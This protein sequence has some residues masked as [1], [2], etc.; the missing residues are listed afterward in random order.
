MAC[1][2]GFSVADIAKAIKLARDIYV[3]CFTE[4]Q[5]ASKLILSLE[6][7]DSTLDDLRPVM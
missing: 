5:G 7:H 3:S 2:F 6:D 4:G 1:P